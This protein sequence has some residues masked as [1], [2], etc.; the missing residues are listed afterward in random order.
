MKKAFTDRRSTSARFARRR[1]SMIIAQA[2][3]LLVA[4]PVLL[5]DV[6]I[7]TYA[8]QAVTAVGHALP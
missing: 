6:V 2:L 8:M 5:G 7:L 1:R 4:T 3:L